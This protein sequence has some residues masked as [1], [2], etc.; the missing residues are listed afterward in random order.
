MAF[1]FSLRKRVELRADKLLPHVAPVRGRA[2]PTTHTLPHDY[3][4]RREN[5]SAFFTKYKG[6]QIYLSTAVDNTLSSC[7][8]R[9]SIRQAYF[10]LLKR[11]FIDRYTGITCRYSKKFPFL[12][13]LGIGYL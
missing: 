13:T 7:S 3:I 4:R 2:L 5:I 8:T 10:V 1:N 11:A 9:H 6:Y 12:S